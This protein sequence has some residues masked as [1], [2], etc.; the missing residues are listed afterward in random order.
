M[1]GSWSYSDR[2][3]FLEW[4]GWTSI[5]TT[6]PLAKSGGGDDESPR[7]P[8]EAADLDGRSLTCYGIE[9]DVDSETW[10]RNDPL[11]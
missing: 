9:E 7:L 8:C 1:V 4:E 6:R 3:F 10:I 11:L 5:L 2:G